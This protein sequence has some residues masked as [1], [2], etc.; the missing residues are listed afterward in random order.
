VRILPIALAVAAGTAAGTAWPADGPV[1]AKPVPPPPAAPAEPHEFDPTRGLDPNGRIPRVELPPNLPNP[2]RWRYIPEGR[3][4]PGNLLDRFLV[5]S[6]ITPIVYYD[7]EVGFGGGIA[8]T[9]IDFRNQRRQEFAG[10]RLGY[11]TEGQQSYT[12]NWQRWLHQQDLPAGGIIQEERSYVSISAG[13]E[14][15]LT[16]RFS[17]LGPETTQDDETNYSDAEAHLGA[18]LQLS[19]PEPGDNWVLTTGAR[20]ERHNLGHGW[21]DGTPDTLDAWPAL[22][23]PAD[24]YLGGWVTLGLRYDTR[25]SLHNPYAG[26]VIGATV[27]APLVQ[28]E[29]G[30]GAL[31]NLRGAA[32]LAVPGLFHGGGDPGEENPPTDT[33]AIGAQVN[34]TAG[35]MPF[36]AL[37]SL[38]GGDTLR[39]Y[40][41]HRWTDRADWHAAAEYRFWWLPRGFTFTDTLRIERLGA[42]FFYDL[43]TVA[44]T[45]PDLLDAP[46]HSSY[47]VSLRVSLERRPSSASTWDSRRRASTTRGRTG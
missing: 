43:G 40:I 35:D 1:E 38:G 21:V 17:G 28:T 45:V 39:G 27:D 9:D 4:K 31:F 3:L 5:S 32:V 2:D 7:S 37:P 6:F 10:I 18:T 19:L 22:F 13:Y 34:A 16:L 12:I 11:S 29:N 36:W 33:I 23:E 26:W 24:G 41:G 47:G 15:S 25:D 14:K 44:G 42:A 8:I 30:P 20:V 46:V